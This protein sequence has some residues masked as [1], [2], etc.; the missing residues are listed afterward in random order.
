MAASRIAMRLSPL[1]AAAAAAAAAAAPRRPFL[2][3][4]NTR[5]YRVLDKQREMQMQQTHTFAKNSSVGLLLAFGLTVPA[6]A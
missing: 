2:T 6:L 1:R 3:R 5:G 4:L